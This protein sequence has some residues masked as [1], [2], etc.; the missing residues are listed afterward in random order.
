MPTTEIDPITVDVLYAA[1]HDLK[2]PAG[3]LRMLAQ[4]LGREATLD[5]DARR[6]LS[7]IED[8]AVAVGVVADGLRTYAEICGRRPNREPVDLN[9]ALSTAMSNSRAE[10]ESAGMEVAPSA[11]PRVD[12]DL[13]MMTWLFQE[14][15][16]N[17]LR[18]RAPQAPQV[19]ISSGESAP[20]RWFVSV[21]DNGPGIEADLADRVFKPFKKLAG[22]SG[23]GLGL[24]ICRKI[25]EMHEGRIWVE[26][27]TGG[28]DLRFFVGGNE[29]RP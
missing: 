22:G 4:L 16:A 29:A 18:F 17:A 23:A 1:V 8:S 14:L 15:L 28:A 3:R 26:P 24:T 25:V 20:G 13:F 19:C 6:L 7:H 10:M 11:L 9:Q 2:G 27:C 5:E 21:R 12:A